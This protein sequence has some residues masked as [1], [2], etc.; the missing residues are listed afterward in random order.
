MNLDRDGELRSEDLE[1]L[2]D[3]LQAEEVFPR[4][5]RKPFGADADRAP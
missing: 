4:S 5:K 2:L 3:R 1:R